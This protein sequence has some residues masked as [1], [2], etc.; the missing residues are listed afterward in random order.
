MP[1]VRYTTSGIGLEIKD[2]VKTFIAAN[3]RAMAN[4]KNATIDDGAEALANAICYAI[5]K[6]LS[7]SFVQTGFNSGI[8][9]VPPGAAVPVGQ[10][11]YNIMKIGTVEL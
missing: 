5:S 1:I 9:P 11:I 3:A 8:V 10:I 7:S 4:D 2:S 6:A